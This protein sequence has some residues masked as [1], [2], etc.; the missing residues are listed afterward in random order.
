MFSAELNE[1]FHSWSSARF[2]SLYLKPLTEILSKLFLQY[3]SSLHVHVLPVISGMPLPRGFLAPSR[4]CKEGYAGFSEERHSPNIDSWMRLCSD[5]HIVAK[6][7]DFDSRGQQH[8]RSDVFFCYAQCTFFVRAGI[9]DGSRVHFF[10]TSGAFVNISYACF[11]HF[12]RLPL[13][14]AHPPSPALLP[15]SKMCSL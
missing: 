15:S 8:I 7:G 12:A 9:C 2:C 3:H 5:F 14:I 6:I 13:Q 10:G 11:A 1:N 4:R